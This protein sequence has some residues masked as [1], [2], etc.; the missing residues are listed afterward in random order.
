KSTTS[1]VLRRM[2]DPHVTVLRCEPRGVR[3]LMIAA[4]NS[5]AVALDNLSGL[6]PWLSD[7][8]CRLATGGGFA[9]RTLYTD[10]E[11]TH[12]DAMRP[13]LLN[14]IE[15][16]ATRGDLIDR[17]IA[18]TLP[19]IPEEK[20]REEEPFW[21]EFEAAQPKLLGAF[22]DTVVGGLQALPDVRLD[23]LP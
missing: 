18:F 13:V 8:L 17:C 23:H 16:V 6:P 9:T 20:R 21:R 11:E 10:D 15:D 3:D 2:I 22:L 5:W 7:A 4:T 12:F 19:Q 14:G 1:R